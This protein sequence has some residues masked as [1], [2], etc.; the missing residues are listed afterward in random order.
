[1]INPTDTDRYHPLDDKFGDDKLLYSAIEAAT[2]S[3]VPSYVHE[4]DAKIAVLVLVKAGLLDLNCGG[5][6]FV[7]SQVFQRLAQ[8]EVDHNQGGRITS[9]LLG[10]GGFGVWT[11]PAEIQH[12]QHLQRLKLTGRCDNVAADL[13]SIHN[14]KMIRLEHCTI[15]QSALDQFP[16]LPQVTDVVLH[17]DKIP[18]Q[19]IWSWIT[20]KLDVTKL[21]RL[22]LRFFRRQS[23][24]DGFIQI[25]KQQSH[26]S[27]LDLEELSIPNS[28]LTGDALENLLFDDGDDVVNIHSSSDT[29]SNNRFPK[30]TT[31]N[32][33]QNKI[34]S[35]VSFCR[36]VYRSSFTLS[37]TL[38]NNDEDTIE[39]SCRFPNLQ[40]L[41]IS[42]NPVV[43]RISTSCDEIDDG[44][45]DQYSNSTIDATE[46]VEAFVSLIQV[47]PKLCNLGTHLPRD[48]LFRPC[49][50]HESINV[51]LRYNQ[52][53]RLMKNNP[54]NSIFGSCD[55]ASESNGVPLSLWPVILHRVSNLPPSPGC[56][57]TVTGLNFLLRHG[58]P[59][60]SQRHR[61]EVGDNVHHAETSHEESLTGMEDWT[62]R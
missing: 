7:S 31:L 12:L 18:P 62:D 61:I 2:P 49:R 6:R 59:E 54:I 15:S 41:N 48:I 50:W 11:L 60:L 34:R 8:I 36:R 42:D 29:N 16:L 40:T 38:D 58:P 4:Q 21:K 25:L 39:P 45:E 56:T 10:F 55:E 13:R 33:Q 43:H 32:L 5:Q 57:S 27:F 37:G 35:M 51:L 3:I 17:C 26:V 47:C 19:Q 24:L 46:E 53:T 22:H 9:L 30:L 44:D 1:M 14:L 28:R 20:S 52:F 23:Y